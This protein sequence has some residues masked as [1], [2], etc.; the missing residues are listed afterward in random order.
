[1]VS[2]EFVRAG[3]RLAALE[4]I[5]SGTTTFADMYYFE[6]EIAKETKAAGLRGVLG[7]TV[8]QFPVA[9]A[10]T[11]ADALARAETFIKTFKNDPLDHACRRAARDLHERQ[12]NA[13]GGAGIVGE[14][15]RADAHS[16]GRD[17][18]RGDD[19][20]GARVADRRQLSRRRSAFSGR[21]WSRHT[22]SG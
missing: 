9:D 11:P 15:Q 14:V 2:P 4:M 1:M 6:E 13:E 18:G 20:Q 12:R 17:A 22:R 16:R 10:K 8:I 21:A 19:R 7:E 3:T 5:E